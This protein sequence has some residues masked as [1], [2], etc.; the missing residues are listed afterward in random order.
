ML[1]VYSDDLIFVQSVLSRTTG[2]MYPR[3]CRKD[4][5]DFRMKREGIRLHKLDYSESVIS[6]ED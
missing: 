5:E 3:P 4:Q 1:A 2:T 6:H